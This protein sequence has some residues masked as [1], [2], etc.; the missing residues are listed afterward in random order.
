M[1]SAQPSLQRYPEIDLLRTFAICGMVVYHFVFMGWYIAGWNVD[2][3]SD[4][5]RLLAR[6]TSTTFL[7]LV[8]ISF[9]LASRRKQTSAA[10]WARAIQRSLTV[11]CAA[12]VVTIVT[13]VLVPESYIRFG[14]LH[15]IGLSMI[16]LPLFRPLKEGNILLGIFTLLI[17]FQFYL[18]PAESEI[19]LP[20]GLIP[21]NFSTLDYFPLIPWFGIVLLGV[22]VGSF[23]YERLEL[24]PF[25]HQKKWYWWTLPGKYALWIYLIHPILIYLALR[26]HS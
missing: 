4:A 22:G 3:L 6:T 21:K 9:V 1:N 7:F 20:F 12:V 19:F 10:V 8:G 14:I 25:L 17:G 24:Q 16:L 11:L 5:W 2:P 26:L 13:I 18:T 15:C 23:L